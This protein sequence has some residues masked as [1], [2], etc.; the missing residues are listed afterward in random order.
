MIENEENLN[1][2]LED[3]P[4]KHDQEKKDLLKRI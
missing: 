3:V 2:V 4:I 1:S